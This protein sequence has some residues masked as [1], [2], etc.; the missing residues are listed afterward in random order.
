MDYERYHTPCR[1]LILTVGALHALLIAST[2]T[3]PT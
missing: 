2:V 3:A 1:P